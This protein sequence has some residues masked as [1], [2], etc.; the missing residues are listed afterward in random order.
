MKATMRTRGTKR[1]A[2]RAGGDDVVSALTEAP[3]GGASSRITEEKGRQNDENTDEGDDG[4]NDADDAGLS[5]LRGGGDP[6]SVVGEGS[7]EDM[8]ECEQLKSLVVFAETPETMIRSLELLTEWKVAAERVVR[9]YAKLVVR[10]DLLEDNASVRSGRGKNAYRSKLLSEMMDDMNS[11]KIKDFLMTLKKK[12]HVLPNGWCRWS[13]SKTSFC[14]IM[15]AGAGITQKPD[16]IM[17]PNYWTCKVV[18]YVNYLMSNHRNN[19]RTRIFTK[20][21]GEIDGVCVCPEYNMHPL[22]NRLVQPGSRG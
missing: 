20:F 13:V 6:P 4:R 8:D 22:T 21:K 9:A 1:G 15:L 3:E 18:P 5:V 2:V 16:G 17:W 11:G 7:G 14:Q 12:M 19:I 10:V